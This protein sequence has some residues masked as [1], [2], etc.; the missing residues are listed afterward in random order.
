M[1]TVAEE[2][3]LSEK[4]V[5]RFIKEQTGQNFS[6]HVEQ[7]RMQRA[8][9]LLEQTDWTVD[10]IARRTPEKLAMLHVSELL[11]NTGYIRGGCSP[12]GMKKHYPT[13]VH[14]SA[15]LYDY[16][17][18]SAGVRGLQV[19]LSPNDLIHLTRAEIYPL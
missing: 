14:E 15:F 19:K 10:E 5:S 6:A 16:I 2:F 8:R 13:Y 9:A 17:Y 1:S 11:A 3:K 18:I 4:Y 7:K 12:I